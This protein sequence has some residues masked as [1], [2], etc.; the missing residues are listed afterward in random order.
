M[1]FKPKDVFKEPKRVKHLPY[2][3]ILF[4]YIPRTLNFAFVFALHYQSGC[5]YLHLYVSCES[6]VINWVWSLM[7]SDYVRVVMIR[8]SVSRAAG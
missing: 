6:E 4:M 5:E 3:I 2:C 8:F 7:F 1:G